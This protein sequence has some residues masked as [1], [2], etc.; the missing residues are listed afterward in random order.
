MVFSYILSNGLALSD[1]EI[2]ILMRNFE[3]SNG[4]IS[5]QKL[6]EVI[7]E[8]QYLEEP[9]SAT[10]RPKVQETIPEPKSKYAY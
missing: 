1:E 3:G 6:N 8:K 9:V 10:S 4:S 5:Y 7:K 2:T